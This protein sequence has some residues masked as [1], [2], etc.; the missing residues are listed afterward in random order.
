MKRI[1][2]KYIYTLDSDEPIINGFI[3][4]NTDG[5]IINI[6]NSSDAGN[7][8]NIDNEAIYYD[9]AIIPGMVNTHCHIEL[10]HLEG[11]F[12]KYTGM[13]GFIDQINELRDSKTREEKIIALKKWIDK[14]WKDGVSAMGD[15]SN[16]SDSFKAKS[17]S[18]MY[19]RTFLEV[20][21]SEA[22][23]CDSVMEMILALK[24]EA[25]ALGIDA[26]PTPHSC[27]TTSPELLTASATEGLKSGYIS[28][29]SQ[30]SQEEEDM[31]LS[32]TGALADNRRRYNMSMPPVTGSS[33]LK[34]FLK[35]LSVTHPGS[36]S[37]KVLL[38]HNVCLSQSDIDE[39]K[40]VLD[41]VYWAICP[42]SNIFIHN[43][44]PPVE[45]MRKNDL[46][47]T[48]GTDSL[49]SNDDLDMVKEMYCLQ[50]N[51]KDL[52]LNEMLTWACRNGAEFLDKLENLGTLTIGKKPGLVFIDNLDETGRLTERSRSNRII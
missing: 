26:A 25:D 21:G 28:Y 46:K 37:S 29:H 24:K 41:K 33:S 20:F 49:S 45:L 17:E 16:G 47:V 3:D 13:A 1:T 38:V 5:T 14:L 4:Y 48:I 43:S 11:A 8:S 44:L 18:P 19:F 23:D 12:K 22:K 39:T 40:K 35:R 50:S 6:G 2:A 9:G 51:F 10:S 52:S 27:Y 42:I 31:I 7:S 36:I 30:E 34:Y 32:G 15:I